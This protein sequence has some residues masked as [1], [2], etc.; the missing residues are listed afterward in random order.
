MVVA[1]TPTMIN[2]R[3]TARPPAQFIKLTRLFNRY[4]NDKR[5]ITIR[6]ADVVSYEPYRP[7]PNTG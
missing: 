6:S 1:E 4:Y 3:L 5:P 2:S 7:E